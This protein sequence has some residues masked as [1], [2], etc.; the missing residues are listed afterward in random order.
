MLTCQDKRGGIGVEWTSNPRG[1]ESLQKGEMWTQRH[2][3]AKEL[4]DS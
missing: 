4:P 3:I 1:P 2:V